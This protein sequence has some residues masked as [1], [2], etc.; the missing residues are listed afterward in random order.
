VFNDL[1]E[2]GLKRVALIVSDDFTG[3]DKAINALFPKSDHQLCHVHLKKN[4]QRYMGKEDAKTFNKKL[5]KREVRR[6]FSVS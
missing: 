1:I 4:V 5:D 3:I 2:I 6:I